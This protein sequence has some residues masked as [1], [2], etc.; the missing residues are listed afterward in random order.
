MA[1]DELT[2]PE[3]QNLLRKKRNAT[4][5]LR[6]KFLKTHDA[7]DLKP[8]AGKGMEP[9]PLCECHNRNPCPIDKELGL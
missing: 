9:D 7:D 2:V 8:G 6:N 1:K 3:K 4:F 5:K